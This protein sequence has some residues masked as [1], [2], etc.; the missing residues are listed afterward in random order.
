MV[1]N[2][3]TGKSN[4]LR[5]FKGLPFV[6]DYR[7]SYGVEFSAKDYPQNLK[8]QI[9]DMPGDDRFMKIAASY[10]KGAHLFIIVFDV[11]NRNSFESISNIEKYM[12]Q[13]AKDYPSVLIIG[14]KTDLPGRQ[15]NIEEAEAFCKSKGYMYLDLSCK[16][17][18]AEKVQTK[19][20]ELLASHIAISVPI[21]NFS[22]DNYARQIFTE[23]YYEMLIRMNKLSP[24]TSRWNQS[25]NMPSLSEWQVQKQHELHQQQQLQAPGTGQNRVVQI[26]K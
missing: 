23:M 13:E 19:F 4:I 6:K 26:K 3:G 25:P 2:G 18:T 22:D 14:N 16:T 15:V 20:D 10:F 21:S 11:T 5:L 24:G 8:F 17:D 7:P 9:W 1:G 12:D